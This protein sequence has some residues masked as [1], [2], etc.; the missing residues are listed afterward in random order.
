MPPP[1]NLP[2][3][4]DI[5]RLIPFARTERQR[6]ALKLLVEHGSAMAVDRIMGNAHDVTSRMVRTVRQY[7][8][9]QGH[10]PEADMVHEVPNPFVVRGV[11]TF[12]DRDGNVRGQWVKSKLDEQRRHEILEAYAE[13]LAS[14]VVPLRAVAAPVALLDADLLSVYPQGDP[15]VGLYAWAEETGSGFDLKRFEQV[16]IEAVER[17][18]AMAPPSETAI[19]LDLGDTTHADNDK[20]RT[21]RSG[22]ELDVHGRHLEVIRVNIRVKEHQ[23]ALML[24]KHQKVIIRI[25]PGNHDP[26]TALM[27]ALMLE[28]RYRNEPRV[29]VIT[30]PNPYWYHL[31]GQCLI[32]STHGHGAKANDLPLVMA[33]DVPELWGAS[34][35]RHWF[36]GHLHHKHI[37]D[38]TGVTVEHVRTLAPNDAHHHLEGYRSPKSMECVTFHRS[39]GEIGRQ[40]WTV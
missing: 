19:F 6:E 37:K 17:L 20:A 15:H 16:S 8:A 25:N 39:R 36:V 33:T 10:A 26:V 9:M 2:D 40:C 3:V 32:A 22:H 30:S 14:N 31:F 21:P 23:I 29:E 28:A 11:S 24:A 38:L 18:V 34:K 4:E 12:Y 13:E 5:R 1:H 7:A 27:I 35:F